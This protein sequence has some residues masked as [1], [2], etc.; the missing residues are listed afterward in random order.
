M[1]HHDDGACGRC[2]NDAGAYGVGGQRVRSVDNLFKFTESL[3]AD[4]FWAP[5]AAALA[6]MAAGVAVPA[7]ED[8]KGVGVRDNRQR[9]RYFGVCANCG[10]E[11]GKFSTLTTEEE[12]E[13]PGGRGTAHLVQKCKMCVPVRTPL[14]PKSLPHHSAPV[15]RSPLRHQRHRCERQNNVTIVER[16]EQ[17]EYTKEHAEGE[18][19]VTM[20]SFE[21]RGVELVEFSPMVSAHLGEVSAVVS[22]VGSD[23]DGGVCGVG[24]VGGRTGGRSRARRRCSTT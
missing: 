12:V 11:S 7:P 21:C 9:S 23:A 4:Y 1:M 6:A 15:P 8:S 10:E 20:V 18:E 22:G 5:S 17:A 13:V 24:V 19:Y 2:G 14:R 16:K 3:C